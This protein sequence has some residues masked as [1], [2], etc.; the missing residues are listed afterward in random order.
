LALIFNETK[1]ELK[2]D[3][4]FFFFG[5]SVNF[6]EQTNKTTKQGPKTMARS[7]MLENIYHSTCSYD[8]IAMYSH[9]LIEY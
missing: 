5:K 7:D 8:K 2:L 3:A 4:F 6:I 1:L 9:V